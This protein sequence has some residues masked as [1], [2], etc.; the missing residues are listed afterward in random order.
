MR[1]KYQKVTGWWV[2]AL[3]T[4]DGMFYI[5][6]S[7]RKYCCERWVVS[8]YI[9]TSLKPYIEKYGW[10]NIRKVVLCDGLTEMQ[11]RQLEDLLIQEA[12][13]SGFCIN[14]ERSGGEWGSNRKKKEKEHNK[15]YY[16]DHL[17]YFK[18]HNEEYYKEHKE[19][20]CNYAK[21]RRSTIEG[22][23]YTRVHNYNRYHTPIE[24]PQEAKQKYLEWGYIPD[25]IKNDD[26]T[27]NMV[28]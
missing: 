14:K 24:T 2:Y 26:L 4:P 6:C 12:T 16:A 23:I 28:T 15:K 25:Y 19:E 13:N 21:Q 11:A 18:T 3:I 1:I 5:G 8:R 9:T 22:K 10:E 27:T 17:E 20:R 7:G